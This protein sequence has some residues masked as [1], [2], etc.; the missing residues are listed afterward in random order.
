MGWQEWKETAKEKAREHIVLAIFA[1]I[2]LLLLA[3]WQAVPSSLWGTVSE[4]TPKRA[5]WALIALEL[6]AICGLAAA[7][8]EKW[9]EPQMLKLFG[10]LWDD[11]QNPHCPVDKTL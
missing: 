3:I 6:I 9:W 4:A 10:M 1:L 2:G 5:L 7:L 11:K 8:I